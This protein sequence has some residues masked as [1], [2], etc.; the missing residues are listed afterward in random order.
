[1]G[2]NVGRDRGGE[3]GAG[4]EELCTVRYGNGCCVASRMG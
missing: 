4:H 2:R 3:D 1:M